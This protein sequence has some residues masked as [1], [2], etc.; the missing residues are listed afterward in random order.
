M[1]IPQQQQQHRAAT[2]PMR[3][4]RLS[5]VLPRTVAAAAADVAAEASV[6]IPSRTV[7][8]RKLRACKQSS[9]LQGALAVLHTMEQHDLKPSLASWHQAL[10]VC[11]S[12]WRQAIALLRKMQSWGGVA[13]DIIAINTVTGACAKDGQWQRALHL[14][15]EARRRG[16]TPDTC[17]Y[18]SVIGALAR[19]GQHAAAVGLLDEMRALGIP[20]D[21][22]TYR[23]AAIG[24][25]HGQMWEAAVGLVAEA[26][27]DL[28]REP[29][30]QVHNTHYYTFLQAVLFIV[31]SHNA[32]H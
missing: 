11:G 27:A 30:V 1:M 12:D 9:D 25:E 19:Q 28:G 17:S 8:A 24:C 7:L 20:R 16:L 26:R 15:G 3:R 13:P 14:L 2:V 6:P 4:K 5:T 23:N 22:V 32:N 31:C 10:A 29:E 21:D 18:N